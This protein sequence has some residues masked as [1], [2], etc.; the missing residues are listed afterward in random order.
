MF[1]TLKVKFTTN[2]ILTMPDLD[3]LLRVETDA[4]DYATGVILSMQCEN[5]K[6]RPCAFY[7]KSLSNVERAYEVH[8]KEMLAIIR[9]LE[10]WRHHL[11]GAKH[12][13]EI[14]SDHQNLQFYYIT[15]HE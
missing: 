8:D 3:Q 15:R 9:A 13:V 11:E 7:S 2:P 12:K 10:A 5:D 4:S 6:W 1:D 14:W